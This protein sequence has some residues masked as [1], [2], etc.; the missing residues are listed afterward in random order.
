[1]VSE[2]MAIARGES[3]KMRLS[4]EPVAVL[5]VAR[6]VAT[7]LRTTG[8]ERQIAVTVAGDDVSVT[9]DRLRLAEALTN[10]VD[11]A[12]KYNRRGG[13]VDITVSRADGTTTIT[14][15]DT[16]IGIKPEHRAELF[17][18]FFREA[19]E[20]GIAGTGL[21]LYGA[22]KLVEAMGGSIRYETEVDKGTAFFVDFPAA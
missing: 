22:K 14:I 10:L 20:S 9:T 5:S 1:M 17:K 7:N 18:P 2:L 13:K 6:Q 15:R 19:R 21:G 3:G 8:Q 16:G 12:I 11:N 4:L